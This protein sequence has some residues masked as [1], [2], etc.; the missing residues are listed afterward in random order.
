MV[1]CGMAKTVTECPFMRGANIQ[2]LS[3]SRVLVVHIL[4]KNNNL[5]S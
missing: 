4:L 5:Y 3:M 2:L 1:V